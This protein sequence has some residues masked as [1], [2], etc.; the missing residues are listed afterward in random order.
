MSQKHNIVWFK[1]DLRITDHAP[2]LAASRQEEPVIP[3]YI[4]EPDRRI[5][6]AGVNIALQ[7]IAKIL[8]R[9]LSAFENIAGRQKHGSS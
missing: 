6:I 4:V 5:G 9:H 1:R 2:L 3:L 7:L 8:S